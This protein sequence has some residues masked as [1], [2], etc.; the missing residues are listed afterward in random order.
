MANLKEVLI[1]LRSNFVSGADESE[2]G[3]FDTALSQTLLTLIG[4]DAPEQPKKRVY[5]R[6]S[7]T[8]A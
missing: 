2:V 8:T 5:V 7:K 1:T 4:D 3:K 6:K